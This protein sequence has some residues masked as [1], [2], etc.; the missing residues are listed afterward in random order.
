MN[1]QPRHARAIALVGFGQALTPPDVRFLTLAREQ[2]PAAFGRL[3]RT[4]LRT[5]MAG[6]A[7]ASGGA[8]LFST[9]WPGAVG[10][11]PAL[12]PPALLLG[13]A[14]VPF[15]AASGYMKA[16]LAALVRYREG[17]LTIA[18]G[19]AGLALAA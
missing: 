14:A 15:T 19:S 13:L 17:A 9:M 2:D 18:A 11:A 10:H 4:L 3:Y 1:N 7:A 6:T 12:Y 8:L 5:I 16:V